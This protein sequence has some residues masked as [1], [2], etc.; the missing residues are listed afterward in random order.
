MNKQ[1]KTAYRIYFTSQG[2]GYEIYARKVC[3]GDMYGFVEIEDIIFGEK[4]AIVV[5]PNEEALKKEFAGVKRL[6]IPYHSV[7]RIDEVEK[8]G[9]ARIVSLAVSNIEGDIVQPLPPHNPAK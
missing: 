1:K 3:Q 5:D 4:S 9:Q 7:S 6:L 2:K 8:E